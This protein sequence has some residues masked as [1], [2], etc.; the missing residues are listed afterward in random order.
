MRGVPRERPAI[1]AAAVGAQVD[2]EDAGRAAQHPLQ[3][4]G[5]VELHVRGEPEPVAQRAGERPRPG[6][7]PDQRERGDVERDRRGAGSLADHDVDPEVL[8]REVEHLLGGAGDAVDL[9][10]E[11]HVARD[12][13]GQHRGEVARPLQGG[14]AGEPDRRAELGGDDHREAG[15]AQPGRPGEQHV[16]R[17][18]PRRRAPSSTSSSCSRTRACP[19][20]SSSRAGRRVVSSSTSAGSATADDRPSESRHRFRPS[21]RQRRWRSTAAGPRPRRRLRPSTA[22]TACSAGR[23]ANPSPTSASTTWV[24]IAP[25]DRGWRTAGRRGCEPADL[26][27]QLHDQPLGDLAPDARHPGERREVALGQRRAQRVRVEHGQ[28]GQ[29]Q[30][31]ADAGHRL[32]QPEHLAPPASA[33]P[34][35]VSESSRTT[36]AVASRACSPRRRVGERGGGGLHRQPT[37][38]PTSTTAWSSPTDEHLPAHRGDHR[39]PLSCLA[40]RGGEPGAVGAGQPLR[41]ASACASRCVI[42]ARQQW[43]I[44]S[45]SA[46]AASAGRGAPA[47]RAS[48]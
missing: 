32:Q 13:V 38:P 8:H 4:G 23:A 35:S 22:S 40:G 16:V 15:L 17:A 45:A 2:V 37:P 31:R 19:T 14:P 42:G 12:E 39:A 33:K 43:Q 9:V 11:Q 25:P 29:R 20:N 46:S 26:V 10:D 41:L 47:A 27:S 30:P 24:R 18:A 6:G 1:S 28:R 44:A 36:S 21:R 34:K 3:L 48:G 5:L 7:G